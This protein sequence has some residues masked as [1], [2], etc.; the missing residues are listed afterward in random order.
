MS[1][2]HSSQSGPC[3]SCAGIAAKRVEIV[4]GVTYLDGIPVGGGETAREMP[5]PRN[6]RHRYGRGRR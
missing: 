2:P 4:G 6:Q 5:Q 1:C 3:S